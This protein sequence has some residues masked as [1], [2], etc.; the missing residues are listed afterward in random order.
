M[1]FGSVSFGTERAAGSGDSTD[2]W[3]ARL[4][5]QVRTLRLDAGLDQVSCASLADVGLSSLKNLENGRGTSL[6]TLVKVLRAL[7]A[8]DWLETLA[9]SPTISPLDVLRRAPATP[10]RRVYR[11][12]AES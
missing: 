3:E 4:G 10:R 9:P 12:R 11:P 2:D 1:T 5:E 6:R 8:V 7:N